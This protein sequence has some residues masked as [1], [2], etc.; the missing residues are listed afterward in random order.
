[1]DIFEKALEQ[2]QTDIKAYLRLE[3]IEDVFI[4]KFNPNNEALPDG[5]FVSKQSSSFDADKTK[6]E[7]IKKTLER[8]SKHMEVFTYSADKN[9]SQICN[10]SIKLA[11]K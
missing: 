2:K 11:T 5:G 6:P 3:K 10:K 7:S 4:K 1:M 9:A 8:Y